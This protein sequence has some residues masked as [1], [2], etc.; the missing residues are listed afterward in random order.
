M[1][2]LLV[3]AGSMSKE[4]AKV[5]TKSKINFDVVGRG[6][7]NCNAFKLL[8][9]H[10]T[11]YKGGFE[12]LCFEKSYSHCIICSDI[13]FL[14]NHTRIAINSGINRILLEKPGGVNL[15]EIA[16]LAEFVQLNKANV[17]V[18]YNRRFY[19]SILKCKELIAE[20]GGVKSFNF[21][22]T[23]WPHVFED[24]Q[25]SEVVKNNLLFANSTHVID[26]AFYIGG[27]PKDFKAFS[28][29]KL[30]WHKKA[31]FAGAGITHDNA[32]F[33][34]QANWKGPGRWSAEFITEKR[35]IILRPLELLQAQNLKSIHIEQVDLD[36]ELDKLFKPG[37]YLQVNTFLFEP[38]NK[39]L[40]YLNQHQLN[41]QGIY[42][43]ILEGN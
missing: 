10:V 19:S 2:V 25:I 11:V 21:E 9:P 41:C 18:A 30:D 5:L 1:R 23:E 37:L 16:E 38:E 13:E 27:K 20:D 36:D 22:F 28:T 33:S 24:L 7:T 17:V 35:R 14:S 43:V 8:F 42:Q 3:G 6:E 32:L 39:S 4:Y 15:Q 31:V 34:Y 29:D 12:A 26:L 40:I